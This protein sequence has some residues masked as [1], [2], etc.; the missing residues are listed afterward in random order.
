MAPALHGEREPQSTQ[1]A[2]HEASQV[3]S[4][5]AEALLPSPPKSRAQAWA[6]P[7]DQP[8]NALSMARAKAEL[9]SGYHLLV[10]GDDPTLRQTSNRPLLRKVHFVTFT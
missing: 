2:R 3:S 7:N 4:A 8:R 1:A 6:S 10:T 9:P 5:E